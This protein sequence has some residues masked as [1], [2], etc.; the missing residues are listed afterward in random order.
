MKKV[1]LT[2][3]F[4]YLMVQESGIYTLVGSKPLTLVEVPNLTEEELKAYHE[5]LT[6]ED[7]KNSFTIEDPKFEEK[8]KQ[9]ERISERFPL[10][11]FLLIRSALN[12]EE[13]TS[14]YFFVNILKTALVIQENY[15][16]FRDAVGFD[17][18]PLETVFDLKN[19]DSK[20]W[21]NIKAVHWGLLFGFGKENSYAFH[22][23][24]FGDLQQDHF[25][26]NLSSYFSN[27][28]TNRTGKFS[29]ENLEI[30]GFISFSK[31]DEIVQ[32]YQ[33]ERAS[34]QYMYKGKDFLN[35]TLEKLTD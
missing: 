20:F 3:F 4:N 19:K 28:S 5:A 31:E 2:Q 17:F 34:I 24:Y 30:P 29:I 21:K 8:W 25:F 32:Q 22:W 10:K 6:E 11:R 9:W 26:E 35:F 33:R 12:E 7:L 14:R 13:N 1:W 27:P 18:H 15:E 16:V 23:K